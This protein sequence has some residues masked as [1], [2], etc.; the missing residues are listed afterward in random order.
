MASAHDAA[1]RAA[2]MASLAAG[3]HRVVPSATALV[4]ERRSAAKTWSVVQV[5]SAVGRRF[6]HPGTCR[7][8]ERAVIHRLGLLE[9]CLP[10]VKRVTLDLA[11][12]HR[13]EPVVL[14]GRRTPTQVRG[15][16]AYRVLSTSKHRGVEI[17]RYLDGTVREIDA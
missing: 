11:G 3:V 5:I 2:L 8:V 15:A 13:V 7:A 14:T 16:P 17:R 4:V 6:Q 12:P 9:S 1:R 10:D